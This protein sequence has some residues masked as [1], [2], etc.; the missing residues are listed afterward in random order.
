MPELRWTLLILGVIF[1]AALAW[2]ERRRPHQASR[3]TPHIGN[4]DTVRTTPGATEPGW[5]TPVS[6]E[7]ARIAAGGRTEPGWGG[8]ASGMDS[9]SGMPS[10]AEPRWETG[11]H[12]LPVSRSD[13]PK[14]DPA[15]G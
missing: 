2:Y 1:I 5:G 15:W 14:T 3:Q 8:S 9:S 12:A 7:A 11:A 4:T 13:D 10:R 6:T